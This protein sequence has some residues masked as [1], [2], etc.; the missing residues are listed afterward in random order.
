MLG[1]FGGGGKALK[2]LKGMCTKSDYCQKVVYFP[3]DV[4]SN[5]ELKGT[6]AYAMWYIIFNNTIY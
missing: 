2:I 3:M 1:V 5:E 4:T 6:Y